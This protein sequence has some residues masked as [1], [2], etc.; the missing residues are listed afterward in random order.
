MASVFHSDLH[1][2]PEGTTTVVGWDVGHKHLAY[3]VCQF[4]LPEPAHD[5]RVI[6][7]NVLQE[8]WERRWRPPRARVKRKY[9]QYPENVCLACPFFRPIRVIHMEVA[10]LCS[11]SDNMYTALCSFF[12][13]RPYL[14]RVDLV[15]V[16]R[17]VIH[18]NPRAA[19]LESA[20]LYHYAWHNISVVR[21]SPQRKFDVYEGPPTGLPDWRS[22]PSTQRR[23]VI[24]LYAE[25]LFWWY[26]YSQR[27]VYEWMQQQRIRHDMC[28]SFLY[29]CCAVLP[30]RIPRKRLSKPVKKR[31]CIMDPHCLSL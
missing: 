15:S 13:D 9:P 23:T 29:C 17:Q 3:C 10:C 30:S 8:E 12:R 18:A 5:D 24:K 4:Y 7:G 22:L 28:D 19:L 20:I 31:R 2:T 27:D 21:V 25:H 6:S 11:S 16:E 26:C 14:M 1:S